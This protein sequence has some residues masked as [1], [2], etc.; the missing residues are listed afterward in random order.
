M[1]M[2]DPKKWYIENEKEK[3]YYSLLAMSNG[4]DKLP[5]KTHFEQENMQLTAKFTQQLPDEG[6]NI[7]K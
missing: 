3:S 1:E 2:D 6:K 4:S 5:Q 7:M